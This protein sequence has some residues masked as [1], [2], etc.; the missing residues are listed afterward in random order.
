MELWTK[1]M[2]KYFEPKNSKLHLKNT[3]KSKISLRKWEKSEKVLKIKIN[4]KKY[5][6]RKNGNF[7][8]N[9]KKK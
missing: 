3:Q 9:K 7:A 8:K 5:F 2:E 1:F 6:G 4:L